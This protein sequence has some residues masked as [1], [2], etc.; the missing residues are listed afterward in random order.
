MHSLS[1]GEYASKG[2]W[3][4]GRECIVLFFILPPP[5]PLKDNGEMWK[6]GAAG[7]FK[8][9]MVVSSKPLNSC[10]ESSPLCESWS[11]DLRLGSRLVWLY[12]MSSQSTVRCNDWQ[13]IDTICLAKAPLGLEQCV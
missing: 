12:S 9:L 3:E 11:F 2:E 10:A 13:Q 6:K 8:L 4:E 7:I 1:R 5:S